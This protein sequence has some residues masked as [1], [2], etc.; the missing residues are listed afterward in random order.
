[1]TP[2]TAGVIRRTAAI[3]TACGSSDEC[4]ADAASAA[5]PPQQHGGHVR[6]HDPAARDRYRRRECEQ[7]LGDDRAE[8]DADHR[9]DHE[10]RGGHTSARR[11]QP[12]R[13]S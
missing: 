13:E 2:N 8:L 9:G 5:K 11:D 7:V 6:E 1:M 12:R 3:S 4:T 10:H